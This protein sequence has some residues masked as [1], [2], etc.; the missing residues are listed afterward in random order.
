VRLTRVSNGAV[1][2]TSLAFNAAA[3]VLTINP[4]GSLLANVQYRVTITGGNASVRD[5][6]GNPFVTRT[7][8]FTTG[9]AA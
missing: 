1:V 3:R 6:A 9:T 2:G 4:N 5:L 7:W 8:V